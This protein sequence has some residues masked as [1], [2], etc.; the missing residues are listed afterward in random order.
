[1]NLVSFFIGMTVGSIVGI[2]IM[3]ICS[4]GKDEYVGSDEGEYIDEIKSEDIK[5][6]D[7]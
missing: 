2:F 4:C 5:Y 1:M 7:R 6:N 3:A